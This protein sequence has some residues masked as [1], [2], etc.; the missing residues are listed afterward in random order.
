[1]QEN[2]YN[3]YTINLTRVADEQRIAVV[4]NT[5]LVIRVRE[6]NGDVLTLV[7][8]TVPQPTFEKYQEAE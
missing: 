2:E 6:V 3:F 7:S 8:Q 4:N 5:Q 1:M